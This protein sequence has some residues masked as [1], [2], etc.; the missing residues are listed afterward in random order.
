MFDREPSDDSAHTQ[1]SPCAPSIQPAPVRHTF[2][3]LNLC[4]HFYLKRKKKSQIHYFSSN[5]P[6][7][8]SEPKREISELLPLGDQR[9]HPS[10]TDVSTCKA[11]T[12]VN[13]RFSALQSNLENA[14]PHLD[15]TPLLTQDRRLFSK[16]QAADK[17]LVVEVLVHSGHASTTM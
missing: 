8:S 11:G 1:H 4:C 12:E 6:F 5:L 10:L 17:E 7:F 2:F 3:F 14:L 13:R 16:S 9:E 15:S